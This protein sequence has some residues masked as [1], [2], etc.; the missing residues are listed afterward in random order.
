[1]AKT[2]VN[3]SVINYSSVALKVLQND[4]DEALLLDLYGTFHALQRTTLGTGARQG[5]IR[6]CDALPAIREA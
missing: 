2:T 4:N 6:P 1:M 5:M 3:F